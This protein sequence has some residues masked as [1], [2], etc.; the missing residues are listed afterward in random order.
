MQIP[1]VPEDEVVVDAIGANL[2]GLPDG[3]HYEAE[4]LQGDASELGV[5]EELGVGPDATRWYPEL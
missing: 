5:Q 3:L 4:C 2:K 1:V